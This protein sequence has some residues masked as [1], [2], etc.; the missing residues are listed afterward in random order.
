MKSRHNTA[1]TRHAH[2]VSRPFI[3][4]ESKYPTDA[5]VLACMHVAFGPDVAKLMNWCIR[6]S[7][8]VVLRR[9]RRSVTAFCRSLESEI[10]E[11]IPGNLKD[12]HML[13]QLKGA[14]DVLFLLGK[15]Q[16][17]EIV[18]EVAGRFDAVARRKPVDL[19]S[20]A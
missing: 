20:L 11:M 5:D 3:K 6:T 19:G 1:Q 13:G 8:E 4:T 7:V 2:H 10:R 18:K 16:S 12:A 17:P 9:E 14:Q 15:I